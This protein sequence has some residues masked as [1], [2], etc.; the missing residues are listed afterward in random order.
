MFRGTFAV[1]NLQAIT[2]NVRTI[3]GL[4]RPS[5]KLLVAVKADG[6]GHGAVPAATAALAGGADALGVASLE[7]GLQIRT[8]GI[9]VPILVF[10]RVSASGLPIAAEYDISVTLTS[11]WRNEQIPRRS[12]AVKVHLKLDTGMSRLGYT[13]AEEAADIAKWVMSRED[14]NLVGVYSHLACADAPDDTHLKGQVGRFEQALRILAQHGVRPRL[15]HLANS[16]GTLRNP[17]LHYDMV[18]VGVSAYGYP[19]S[20]D[21]TLSVH[22]QPALSLYARI[23]RLAVIDVGQTVGYGATFTATRRTRVATIP[24]GYADGYFRIL[25]NRSEVWVNG[26][27]APV[28]GNV[29]MD[30]LM[31]DVTDIPE[32]KPLDWVT[33]YGQAVPQI[34]NQVDFS[35][36]PDAVRTEFVLETFTETAAESP[37]VSL[38]RLAKQAGT[39]SYELMCAISPRIPKIYFEG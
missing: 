26:F 5:T 20:P 12:K 17:D 24:I 28:I 13:D 33:V 30:Q 1:V 7:E 25:S 6:Y 37:V 8:A 34:W 15:V 35:S 11:D 4:L 21:F 36:Q 29:C 9:E 27:Y 16:A 22:L 32:V 19:P 39:I 31:I 23:Q 38:D 2:N 18:R 10:G 3:K 14:M